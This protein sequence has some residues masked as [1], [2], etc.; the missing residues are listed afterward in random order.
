MTRYGATIKHLCALTTGSEI[1]DV[2]V[3]LKAISELNGS[4]T[5][6]CETKVHHKD[7]YDAVDIS[8]L[9]PRRAIPKCKQVHRLRFLTEH[10]SCTDDLEYVA[11]SCKE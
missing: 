2:L 3:E 10:F 8:A 7:D 9:V 6:E 1:Q 5:T 4:L 11:K